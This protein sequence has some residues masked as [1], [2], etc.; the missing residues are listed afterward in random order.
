MQQLPAEYL[1]EMARQVGFVSAFLGAL[2]AGFLVTLLTLQSPRRI[3]S[4]T[5]VAAAAA[6]VAFI[7]SVIGS[8]AM[9]ATLHPN[10]PAGVAA[11]ANREEARLLAFVPFMSGLALL[12]LCLGLSGWI[13]SRQT[14]WATSGLALLGAFLGVLALAG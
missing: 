1:A 11:A 8:F 12:L 5:I 10:A 13:R 9:V 6:A 14:G 7:V 4:A 3:V 2:A